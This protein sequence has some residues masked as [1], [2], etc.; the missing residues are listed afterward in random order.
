MAT[1]GQEFQGSDFGYGGDP[2]ILTLQEL[3]KRFNDK[4]ISN[5][6]NSIVELELWVIGMIKEQISL[7]NKGQ[8]G[9]DK[10]VLE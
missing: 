4:E 8:D 3:E 9:K 10:E 2:R 5:D 1:G 6:F 7:L